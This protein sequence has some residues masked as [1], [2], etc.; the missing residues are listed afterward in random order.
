LRGDV[1]KKAAEDAY[2]DRAHTGQLMILN[3]IS[4]WFFSLIT[5]G[6]PEQESKPSTSQSYNNV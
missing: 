3:I 5:D 6:K 2:V 4:Q 1:S